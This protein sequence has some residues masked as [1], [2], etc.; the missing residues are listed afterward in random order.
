MSGSLSVPE[1]AQVLAGTLTAEL[2]PHESCQEM[3]DSFINFGGALVSF[4]GPSRN[5]LWVE[6]LSPKSARTSIFVG[7]LELVR[8]KKLRREIKKALVSAYL[9]RERV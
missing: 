1:P 7:D 4:G 9:E 6:L 3:V 8:L 2:A 5:V